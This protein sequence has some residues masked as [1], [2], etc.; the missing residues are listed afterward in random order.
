MASSIL[1]NLFGGWSSLPMKDTSYLRA[2]IAYVLPESSLD[3]CHFVTKNGK[4][5]NLNP[6]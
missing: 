3:Q 4:P 5:L 2:S 6:F 1:G